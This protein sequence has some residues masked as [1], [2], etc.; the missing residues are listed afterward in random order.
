MTKIALING[1]TGQDGSYLSELLLEKGYKVI[2]AVR[3]L[4]TALEKWEPALLS[5]VELVEWNMLE[6]K[7]ISDVLGKFKPTEFYNFAAYSSGAGMYDDPAG[8]GVVN[9]LAITH[10][11]EAIRDVDKE[12]KFCQASSREIFG[13]AIES[14]Q[15]EDTK[16]SPRSPYGAAKLYA[17]NMIQIYR[18]RYDLFAC[19]AILYNHESPRRGLEFVTRKI[20]NEAVRIKMGL[21]DHIQLGNLDAQRDWGFA[22]DT[23][24]AMW[25]MLQH[26]E[27]GNYIV[28][29]GEIH[30]VRDLCEMAFSYLELDY[31]KY[32]RSDEAEFRPM[33][34]ALLVGKPDKIQKELNWEIKT[35]FTEL[36]EMMVDADMELL[37]GNHNKRGRL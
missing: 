1:V 15:H 22:G 4:S 12:I 35:S 7:S 18:Q 24:D 5:E 9:G 3:N 26:K 28:A 6:Q 32:V 31:K 13:E 30:S 14:P 29:T 19:S 37:S 34:P 23:V 20:T 8:I 21:I 17:D 16:V 33:E 27:A 25:R 11:L 2:G 36:V 10:M